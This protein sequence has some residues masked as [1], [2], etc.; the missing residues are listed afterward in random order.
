MRISDWSSDVCSSDLPVGKGRVPR[1]VTGQAVA[2]QHPDR[3]RA[4]CRKVG[5]IHR[6]ELPRDVLRAFVGKEMHPFEDH[7]MGDR[8]SGVKG[9]SGSVR[10]DLG[11]RRIIK[12]KT[13]DETYTEII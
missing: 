8:K 4:L 1:V 9:K 2:E 13:K 7:V 10:V 5:E 6:D 3:H 12:Q 11:G